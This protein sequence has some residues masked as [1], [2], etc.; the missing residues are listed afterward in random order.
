MLIVLALVTAVVVGG[1]SAL[2]LSPVIGAVVAV[3]IIGAGIAAQ[4]SAGPPRRLIGVV[5]LVTLLAVGT[6][7]SIAVLEVLDALQG[8]EGTADAADPDA[9]AAAESKLEGLG[10]TGAFRLELTEAEL[11]AVIQ[12]GVVA[13]PS[14]PVRRIDVQLRGATAD[15]A[16]VAAFKRGSLTA[17]GIATV[18]TN[19]AGIALQLGPL[20]FGGVAVPAVANASIQSVLG[21]VTDLNAAL[22]QQQAEVQ[23]I[24]IL[25]DLMII[26]GVRTGQPL[27]GGQLLE[28]IR[29]QATGAT[30]GVTAP[31]Q[32]LGPGTVNALEAPGAP[33]VLSI[34]DSLA[35]NVGVTEPRDGYVSRFHAAISRSD[36]SAYGLQNL[37]RAG[38]TS[39]SLL[40]GGQLTMA[41]QVLRDRPAAYVTI[42][43]GANDLLGHLLSPDCGADLRAPACQDRVTQSIEAY[44]DN[45]GVALDR[46]QAASGA[47]T[48]VLLQVYNP[49]SLGL[50]TAGQPP[51]EQEVASSEALQRLNA[52]AGELAGVRGIRVA[53]GFTPMQ[54]TTAAT[55]HMLD[56]EPDIHPNAF[57]YDVLAT[58]VFGAA[59]S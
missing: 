50:G 21:A 35:A 54:G 57:G 51:G 13:D 31:P 24:Q 39:G 40:S 48:I 16:Y 34:G 42:D 45:L 4:L 36:A 20:T 11:Q 28:S 18:R 17:E 6:Y 7:G 55:T 30:D 52:V 56:P 46:I 59:T 23:A 26:T 5:L 3:L 38:E 1:F 49:F 8:T 43:I 25:E 29:Q 2:V 37:A 41:E 12:E 44:R 27:T 22:A 14:A 47:A 58:A 19:G 10:A 53:D 9:L 15:I 33:I 32:V